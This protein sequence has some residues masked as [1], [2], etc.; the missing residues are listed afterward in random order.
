MLMTRKH[1]FLFIAAVYLSESTRAALPLNLTETALRQH[2][3]MLVDEL[4]SLAEGLAEGA[5][6]GTG[7]TSGTYGGLS[8]DIP[9][10]RFLNGDWLTE[11]FQAAAKCLRFDIEN[12]GRNRCHAEILNT[13]ENG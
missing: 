13:N 3:L 9:G 7:P 4:L 8:S 1:K 11:S 5:P 12:P 2:R 10:E 6:L